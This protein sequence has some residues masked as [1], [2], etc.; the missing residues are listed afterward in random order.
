MSETIRHGQSLDTLCAALA[1]AMGVEKPA[2]SNDAHP[3]LCEYVDKAFSG[4]KADRLLM[5]NPDA[6]ADWVWKKYASYLPEVAQHGELKIP[7]QTVMPSVTPV[8]F[9][10]MYT[11]AQPEVHGIQ[12]YVKPVIKIDTLFD[13]LLRAGKK[14][15]ILGD[16]QCS[17]MHIFLE[18]D[19]TYIPCETVSE[20]LARTVELILADEHDVI[21]CYNGNYDSIMHKF[22]PESPEAL[23]E[24]RCNAQAF[25]MLSHLV[26]KNWKQH[27]ALVAFAMDHG[28]HEIDGGC[29]AHGL[30]MPEDID[31]TH[32]YKAYPAK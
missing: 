32:L 26:E 24:L 14:I 28:C 19:I 2:Q 21:V 23:A 18:R 29:G 7:Y 12:A 3:A 22:G 31:I 9:G 20:I 6:I 1:Y 17:L 4:R 10:T 27:D 13:S 8:C 5:Y 11:G 15:A 25:G 16:V 30:D